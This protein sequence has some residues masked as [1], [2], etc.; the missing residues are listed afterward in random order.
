MRSCRLTYVWALLLVG[1]SSARAE[2]NLESGDLV[3]FY[4]DASSGSRQVAER[5]EAFFALRYPDLKITFRTFEAANGLALKDAATEFAGLL[6]WNTPTLVLL[7]FGPGALGPGRLPDE[8]A[9]TAFERDVSAFLEVAKDARVALLTPAG[10]AASA[11]AKYL[12]AV[13]KTRGPGGEPRNNPY[14]YGTSTPEEGARAHEQTIGQIAD[15]LRRIASD[16][17]L[18]LLDAHQ[19]VAANSDLEK[20]IEALPAQGRDPREI[21][22]RRNLL[23]N[24]Y[25]INVAVGLLLDDWQ[26]EPIEATVRFDWQNGSADSSVGPAEVAKP[27]DLARRLTIKSLP[28]P[29]DLGERGPGWWSLVP[30]AKYCRLT[31]LVTGAPGGGVVV[32]DGGL[33]PIEVT[34]GDLAKGFNLACGGPLPASKP[35]AELGLAISKKNMA[36][37]RLAMYYR[38]KYAEPEFQEPYQA[39]LK[40]T[41]L[42]LDA[43]E[44]VLA[45]TPRTADVVLEL[46][47]K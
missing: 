14:P 11:Y 41:H 31:L 34:A 24:L 4:G 10:P 35:A 39:M 36:A 21:A 2:P 22:S 26:A 38:E 28:L 20:S 15:T 42:W 17:K 23:W 19:V 40:A 13:V 30:A 8:A 27:T 29:W 32:N 37:I 33:I 5:V 18:K 9:L 43:Y 47:A 25:G 7:S 12:A 44:K 46:K 45:R 6:A 1:A 3:L 16:R